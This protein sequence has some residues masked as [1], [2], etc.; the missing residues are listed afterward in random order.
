[1]IPPPS[2]TEPEQGTI[3]VVEDE[4]TIRLM[5][6]KKLT[7][8]GWRVMEA[9]NGELALGL[10]LR[11]PPRVVLTDL[12]MPCLDGL[13]L[14]RALRAASAT[15]EIPV[16]LLSARSHRIAASDLADTNIQQVIMKP[17]SARELVASLSEYCPPSEDANRVAA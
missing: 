7:A 4:A 15:R 3:L 10:A 11:E 17:F 5:L 1:M 9:A 8:A 14:A 16:L 6:V 13:G 2:S 12:Q